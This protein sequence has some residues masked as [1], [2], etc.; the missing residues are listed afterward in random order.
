MVVA[1]AVILQAKLFA[2]ISIHAATHRLFV[3]FLLTNNA[4]VVI[5]T[6]HTQ[7]VNIMNIA[8]IKCRS[9][10]VVGCSLK[11]ARSLMLMY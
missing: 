1:V 7:L 2:K 6:E 5:E 9:N 10:Q 11:R 8:S 4:F 3:F